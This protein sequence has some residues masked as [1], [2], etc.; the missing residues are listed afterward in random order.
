MQHF[1]FKK[2][3]Q[4]HLKKSEKL[5]CPGSNHT[6]PRGKR[7]LTSLSAGVNNIK[8]Y[9]LFTSFFIPCSNLTPYQCVSSPYVSFMQSTV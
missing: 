9:S 5:P 3:I 7:R 2:R 6:F 4:N 1:F 8:A